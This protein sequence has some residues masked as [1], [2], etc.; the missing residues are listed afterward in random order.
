MC[1]V[2]S[3]LYERL[4]GQNVNVHEPEP[5]QDAER[6]HVDRSQ[7]ID[8][9]R[10]PATVEAVG[11]YAEYWPE[12]NGWRELSECDQSNPEFGAG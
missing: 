3:T 1:P 9:D 10:C 5:R 8:D 4:G 12:N 11:Q 7:C 2:Q 6:Q